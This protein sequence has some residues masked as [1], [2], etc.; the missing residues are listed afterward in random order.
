MKQ[1]KY[2]EDQRYRGGA[3]MSAYGIRADTN[4][5]HRFPFT[6]GVTAIFQ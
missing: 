4:E 2:P 5:V 3:R 1:G 6:S